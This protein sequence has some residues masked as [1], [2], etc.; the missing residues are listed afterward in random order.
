MPIKNLKPQPK[1]SPCS[2]NIE[3]SILLISEKEKSDEVSLPDSWKRFLSSYH[4]EKSKMTVPG[5]RCPLSNEAIKF[6]HKKL[7]TKTARILPDTYT[8]KIENE[9]ETPMV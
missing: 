8:K 9:S 6:T 1:L 2:Y 4:D 7:L 3:K 5:L